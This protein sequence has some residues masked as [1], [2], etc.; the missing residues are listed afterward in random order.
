M[1]S[2][3]NGSASHEWNPEHESHLRTVLSEQ[4]KRITTKYRAGQ[5]AHGGHLWKK[6]G[7]LGHAEAEVTDLNVYMVTLRNQLMDVLNILDDGTNPT[8]GRN[9][10]ARILGEPEE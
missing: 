4:A 8:E 9:R 6:A 5:R 10:L 1:S 3:G 7:M 2:S